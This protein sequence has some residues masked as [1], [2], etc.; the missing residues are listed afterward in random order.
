MNTKEEREKKYKDFTK[1]GQFFTVEKSP[2]GRAKCKGCKRPIH[3]SVLRFRHIVCNNKCCQKGKTLDVCGR[4]HVNCILDAQ[5]S[6]IDWFLYSN[7]EFKPIVQTFQLD[8]FDK[9][10][11]EDQATIEIL[12]SR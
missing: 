12:L 10:S 3:K 7:P 4:W 2:S 1:K 6:N 9:L 8:G 11:K 5:K